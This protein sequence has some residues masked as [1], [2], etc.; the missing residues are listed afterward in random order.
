MTAIVSHRLLRGRLTQVVEFIF[1]Q[2]NEIGV[3]VTWDGA[4]FEFRLD[5]LL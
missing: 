3:L 5:V 1:G 4:Q 2:V